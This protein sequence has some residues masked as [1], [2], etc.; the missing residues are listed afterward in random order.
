M[1]A[2]IECTASTTRRGDEEGS[3]VVVLGFSQSSS[4]S[5]N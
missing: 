4:G 3:L 2:P 1:V 5:R